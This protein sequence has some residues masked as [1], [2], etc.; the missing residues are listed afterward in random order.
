MDDIF[1]SIA[2]WLQGLTILQA[3]PYA[4]PQCPLQATRWHRLFSH[5]LASTDRSTL[6]I[7]RSRFVGHIESDRALC[8]FVFPRESSEHA[9]SRRL[10]LLQA[11]AITI[12]KFV[13]ALRDI[14]CTSIVSSQTSQP[15]SRDSKIV[16]AACVE[17]EDFG[18][19][20]GPYPTCDEVSLPR[21]HG[22]Y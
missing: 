11:F 16:R 9:S 21:A 2:N 22:G 19:I 4:Q 8:C 10:I 17:E 15:C 14:V 13:E 18:H 20:P 3:T 1:A 6:K 7:P 12:V 5:A